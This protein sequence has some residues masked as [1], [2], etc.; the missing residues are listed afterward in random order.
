LQLISYDVDLAKKWNLEPLM[1]F[2]IKLK[3]KK[4]SKR[5]KEF[6]LDLVIGALYFKKN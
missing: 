4:E 5:K 6:K 3:R 2:L 1:H